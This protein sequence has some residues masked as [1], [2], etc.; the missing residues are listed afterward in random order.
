[1]ESAFGNEELCAFCFLF[2][3]RY[4]LFLVFSTVFFFFLKPESLFL[5]GKGTSP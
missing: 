1:M 4:R 5:H 3:L 2:G